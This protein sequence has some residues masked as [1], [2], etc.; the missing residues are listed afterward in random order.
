MAL[1]CSVLSIALVTRGS[2]LESSSICLATKS[3]LRKATG[4]I[5]VGDKN[6]TQCDP[7]SIVL[8]MFGSSVHIVDFGF[9]ARTEQVSG[10]KSRH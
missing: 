5:T 8:A 7:G 1:L 3:E 2:G 9:Q 4:A 10:E 6:P